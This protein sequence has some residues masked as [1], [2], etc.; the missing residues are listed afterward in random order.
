MVAGEYFP[1]SHPMNNPATLN[2]QAAATGTFPGD[3]VTANR[4]GAILWPKGYKFF[5]WAPTLDVD[6]ML[7][8][9]HYLLYLG[10]SYSNPMVGHF[11]G[12]P[13]PSRLINFRFL[14]RLWQCLSST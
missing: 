5:L 3:A 8:G 10:R 1:F 11:K 6:G 14:N 2:S 13:F 9:G 12:R 4:R 7:P